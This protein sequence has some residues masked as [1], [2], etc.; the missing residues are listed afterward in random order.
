[1]L[2]GLHIE[3][4]MLAMLGKL[5]EGSG[6]SSA[7]VEA[8]IATSGRAEAMLSASHA[9]RTRYAHQVTAASLHV[10]QQSAYQTYY[11]HYS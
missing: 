8:G 1:M 4:A 10:L 2:G 9:K 5:L 7:L 6:W 3:M 11:V